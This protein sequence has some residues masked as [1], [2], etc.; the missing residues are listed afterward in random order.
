[1]PKALITLPSAEYLHQ[2]FEYES[3]TGELRWRR[4]PREHFTSLQNFMSW[5]GK[6][7]GHIAGRLT[8][9]G[10]WQ[11]CLQNRRFYVSR[12]IYKM[13]HGIDP[14][15]IDHKDRDRTNNTLENIRSVTMLQNN[16]NMIK[17]VGVSGLVGVTKSRNRRFIAMIRDHAGG[18][19]FLGTFDTAE[20]A[21]AAYREASTRIHG[22]FSP[23]H[24]QE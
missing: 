5:N 14:E 15:W 2:C 11:V 19:R 7:A 9:K 22:E 17:K 6:W 20:E 21:H 12:I 23:F 16:R 13:H 8:V 24:R 1:M 10:Y 18:K 3:A 4:R